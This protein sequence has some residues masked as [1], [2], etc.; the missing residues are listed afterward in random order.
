[1]EFADGGKRAVRLFF[2]ST[3]PSQL[4]ARADAR[5]LAEGRRQLPD[6]QL[7]ISVRPLVVLLLSNPLSLYDGASR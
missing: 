1:M 7:I 3:V 2:L 5:T 6:W 4:F